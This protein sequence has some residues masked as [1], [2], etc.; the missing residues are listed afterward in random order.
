MAEHI[1]PDR[2]AGCRG[3]KKRANVGLTSFNATLNKSVS[4]FKRKSMIV[5][6]YS[7]MFCIFKGPILSFNFKN[8]R[9][10]PIKAVCLCNSLI[11]FYFRRSQQPNVAAELRTPSYHRTVPACLPQ[12]ASTSTLNNNTSDCGHHRAGQQPAERRLEETISAKWLNV[13]IF[14]FEES[15]TSLSSAQWSIYFLANVCCL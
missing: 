7:H 2:S 8:I 3:T 11:C 4:N 9:N 12:P 13:G 14:I 6:E 15:F 10:Q 1:K 5:G